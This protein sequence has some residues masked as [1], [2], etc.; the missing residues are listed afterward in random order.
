MVKQVPLFAPPETIPCP[1]CSALIELGPGE[2]LEGCVNQEFV[3]PSCGE[4]GVRST[5][6]ER[7]SGA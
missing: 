1:R 7:P 5:N 4:V 6:T 2:V 3:C